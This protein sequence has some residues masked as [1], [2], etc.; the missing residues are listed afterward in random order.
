[1]GKAGASVGGGGGH[2]PT[3]A[4]TGDGG[5]GGGGAEVAGGARPRRLVASRAISTA[6]TITIAITAYTHHPSPEPEDDVEELEEELGVKSIETVCA[7]PLTV[8]DPVPLDVVH[9]VTAPIEY[10]YVPFGSGIPTVVPTENADVPPRVTDQLVPLGR[11][12]SENVTSKLGP[13]PLVDV[14]VAL[15]PSGAPLTVKEPE[16]VPRALSVEVTE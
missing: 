1:M 9:P 7:A 11:P 4:G 15:S 14:K 8:T 13:L 3:A 5:A 10:S 6:T 2:P 12:L 16:R